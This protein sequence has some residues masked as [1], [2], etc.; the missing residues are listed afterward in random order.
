[1]FCFAQV[2]HLKAYDEAGTEAFMAY[3]KLLDTGCD[4]EAQ[5]QPIRDRIAPEIAWFE[6]EGKQAMEGFKRTL[7][8]DPKKTVY[9]YT[10]AAYHFPD[11]IHILGAHMCAFYT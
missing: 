3:R 1:M 10:Y 5:Y 6:K 11:N 7:L 2:K 4:D 9:P 8:K